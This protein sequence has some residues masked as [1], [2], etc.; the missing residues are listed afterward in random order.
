MNIPKIP[1]FKFNCIVKG[2]ISLDDNSISVLLWADNYTL[3]CL[4]IRR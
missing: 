1:E 4:L 2:P 3:E